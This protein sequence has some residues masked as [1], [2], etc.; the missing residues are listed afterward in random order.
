MGRFDTEWK[1]WVESEKQC[2]AEIMER[3]Q[4]EWLQK[5]THEKH[6]SVYEYEKKMRKAEVEELE[7]EISSQKDIIADET[8]LQSQQQI[9]EENEERVKKI[10]QETEQAKEGWEKVQ[11]DKDKAQDSYK[12]YKTLKNRCGI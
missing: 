4:M 7:Q 10:R 1:R 5:G 2:L 3:Y 12:Y 11:I 6:L 9:L 8:A